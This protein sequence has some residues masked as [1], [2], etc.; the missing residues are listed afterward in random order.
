MP[1]LPIGGYFARRTIAR[2]LRGF[3]LGHLD[4]HDALIQNAGN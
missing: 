4:A 3:H 2:L 1:R